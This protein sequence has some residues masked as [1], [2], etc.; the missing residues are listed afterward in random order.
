MKKMVDERIVKIVELW[1]GLNI[2]KRLELLEKL[3]VENFLKGPRTALLIDKEAVVRFRIN[4]L[5]RSVRL[6]LIAAYQEGNFEKIPSSGALYM[7]LKS[8]LEDEIKRA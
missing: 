1:N 5:P 2:K 4:E 3:E 8:L 7:A 6:V